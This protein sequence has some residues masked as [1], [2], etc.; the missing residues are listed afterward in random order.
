MPDVPYPKPKPPTR[1]KVTRNR[2]IEA[3]VSVVDAIHVASTGDRNG[4]L[5]RPILFVIAVASVGIAMFAEPPGHPLGVVA[6][7]AIL[8][9]AL[10]DAVVEL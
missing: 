10:T 6:L 2:V 8:L 3:A 5:R 9:L 4:S 7:V 1:V